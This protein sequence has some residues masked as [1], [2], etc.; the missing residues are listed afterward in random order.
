[1]A[2]CPAGRRPA[3]R[4]RASTRPGAGPGRRRGRD[5]RCGSAH[6]PAGSAARRRSRAAGARDRSAGPGSPPAVASRSVCMSGTAATSARVYGWR[7]AVLSSA[8][9]RSST[10]RPAYMTRTR[11]QTWLTTATSW[12]ISTMATPSTARIEPSRSSTWRCTV[13]SSAV[14]GSSATISAGLPISPIPIIARCRMPPENSCGYCRTRR[15]AAG[16]RT[17]RSRSTARASAWL[18]VMPWCS[19]ATSASCDPTRCVGL[20]DVIGSWN[21]IANEVPSRCRVRPCRPGR[22]GRCPGTPGVRRRPGRA[23]RPAGR[24]PAPSDDLPEPDSP[25]TPT[26]S[27]RRTMKLTPRTGRDQ[28]ARPREGHRQ[29]AHVEHRFRCRRPRASRRLRQAPTAS[30]SAPAAPGRASWSTRS[31]WR[32]P[33]RTG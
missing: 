17:A 19:R 30:R 16:T 27:P 26:A 5:P 9:G 3:R 4:R 12:L 32:P 23:L 33:R 10:I 13:T 20:N 11:S 25:T 6:R 8:A 18:R 21:T 24:S 22:S 2:A 7:A 29:V 15:S 1:M 28:P 31:P 14:V